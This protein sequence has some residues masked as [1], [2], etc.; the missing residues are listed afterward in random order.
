[1][2]CWLV[3][4]RR[5]FL[6]RF[7]VSLLSLY[8]CRAG[9]PSQVHLQPWSQQVSYLCPS[10]H[11]LLSASEQ[12]RETHMEV[13]FSC[14]QL[15]FILGQLVSLCGSSLI[16]LSFPFIA[17]IKRLNFCEPWRCGL[18]CFY[19]GVITSGKMW[20]GKTLQVCHSDQKQAEVKF[21]HV[22]TAWDQMGKV[23]T[24]PTTL[25]RSLFMCSVNRHTAAGLSSHPSIH[26]LNRLCSSG[27]RG[28]HTGQVSSL[29]QGHSMH[30]HVHLQ[31]I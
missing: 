26:L 20:Q 29:L 23:G 2:C 1:M 8:R 10:H 16:I 22:H 4:I 18:Y 15:R 9:G 25:H 28:V 13:K 6:L 21:K 11:L 3:L 19:L 5:R 30:A 24:G 12:G 17:Q 7:T 31:P 27:L 14:Q